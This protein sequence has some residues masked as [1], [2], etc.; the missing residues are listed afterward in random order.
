[1]EHDCWTKLVS[2]LWWEL[3]RL[4]PDKVEMSG[5]SSN[6]RLTNKNEVDTSNSAKARRLILMSK[7]DELQSRR[8]R[9]SWPPEV[10]S[11]EPTPGIFV[12]LDQDLSDAILHSDKNVCQL[13]PKIQKAESVRKQFGPREKRNGIGLDT[14]D[15]SSSS[16]SKAKEQFRFESEIL[17][18]SQP[19]N[20]VASGSPVPP[21]SH[22]VQVKIIGGNSFVELNWLL[23]H[24][25]SVLNY[26]T[27]A[28]EIWKVTP[29]QLYKALL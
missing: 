7:P 1:M 22:L 23:F 11:R 25:L 14:A 2:V 6:H 12:P 4:E 26:G 3:C 8:R 29:F 27:F 17:L 10:D 16:S 13:C 19:R 21:R 5:V 9:R 28:F 20:A 18:A 15:N 24:S